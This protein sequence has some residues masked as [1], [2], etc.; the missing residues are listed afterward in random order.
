[1]A[2][3]RKKNVGHS[4]RKKS[5]YEVMGEARLKSRHGKTLEQPSPEKVD[6]D[7]PTTESTVAVPERAV[8]WPRRPRIVQFNAG[9]IEISIP[10]QLAI[11]FLLG[12]ILLVLVVYRV[13]EG[14]GE[15]AAKK[16]KNNPGRLLNQNNTAGQGQNTNT[17]RKMLSNNGKDKV[18]ESKGNHRIVIQTYEVRAH[19]DPVQRYFNQSGIETEIRTIDGKYCLVTKK[20]YENPQKQGTDG[21]AAKQKIIELGAQYKAPPGYET[22]GVKSFESAYGRKFED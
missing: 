18:A 1:M 12:I 19:L 4:R 5:L 15:S 2:R 6:K 22:F 20:K 9:R 17:D 11:A 13:G 16:Q 8:Q 21:Y 3:N 7:E 10:Y 14:V